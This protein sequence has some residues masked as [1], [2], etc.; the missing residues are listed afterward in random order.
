M[1]NENLNSDLFKKF[2]LNQFEKL[3]QVFGGKG[4]SLTL[5][6]DQSAD[7]S[8]DTECTNECADV[9]AWS[10]D[11]TDMSDSTREQD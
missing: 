7:V 5:S 2:E 1:K 11:S 8:S 3:N 10:T 4:A 9:T 6:T